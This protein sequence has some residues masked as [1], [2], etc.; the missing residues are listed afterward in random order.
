VVVP[1]A[2]IVESDVDI[3]LSAEEKKVRQAL[4]ELE[5]KTRQIPGLYNIHTD[6]TEG[7]KEIKFR[8]NSYGESL[9]FNEA[10]ISQILRPLFL[11]AEIG[12]MFYEGKL[13]RIKS[14][15]T[16]KDR[17]GTL[18]DLI[19]SVPNSLQ[20]VKLSEVVDFII[21]PSPATIFKENGVKIYSLLASLDKKQI[22]SAEFMKEI[23]PLLKRFEDN[24]IS[25]TVKGEEKENK[26]VQEE[27]SRAAVIAIFLIFIALVW[28]FGKISLSLFVLST[29]PLS[30][31]GVLVGHII[32]QMDLTMPGMLGIVGLAGVVVNDG[33]IMIDFIRKAEN[34]QEFIKLATLRLRPILLTSITTVLGLSTLIFFAQGQAV[35][36][37]PMAISLGFGITWATVLNLLFLPV[38]YAS[39]KKI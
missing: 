4:K 38:L 5:E 26:K 8:L 30:V 17:S 24:G 34:R 15:D 11:K 6:L 14:E 22:K 28:M 18:H 13:T 19:I 39:V 31:F 27:M 23:T 36:L 25:V 12:K 32:M 1:G 29:I 20:K 37:Q 10:I 2:G 35:I 33:I 7:E 9:G 21:L 16:G 3:A